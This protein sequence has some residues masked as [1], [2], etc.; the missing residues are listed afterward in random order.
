MTLASG[1]DD[2]DN[3]HFAWI[4]LLA[5]MILSLALALASSTMP[6]H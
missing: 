4:G 2:G 6:K 1:G 3:S 5:K